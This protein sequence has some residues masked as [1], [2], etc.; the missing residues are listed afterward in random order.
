MT[1]W[2]LA[3]VQVV[4]IKITTQ[5]I[6]GVTYM[7][8]FDFEERYRDVYECDPF[9]WHPLHLPDHC[10]EMYEKLIRTKIAS[11]APVRIVKERDVVYN[12]N[13]PFINAEIIPEYSALT[14]SELTPYEKMFAYLKGI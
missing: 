3:L 6:A 7:D 12:L 5:S 1:G 11:R 14:Y 10:A 4:L 8:H 13:Y 9:Y 2:Q